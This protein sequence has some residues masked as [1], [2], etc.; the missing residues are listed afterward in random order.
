MI[1]CPYTALELRLATHD[2]SEEE[3]SDEKAQQ[4]VKEFESAMPH[5]KDNATCNQKIAE[6]HGISVLDLINSPNMDKLKADF[7]QKDVQLILDIYKKHG[8]NDKLAWFMV[9]NMLAPE[10][11]E[12]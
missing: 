6:F 4:I 2:V 1:K 8:L 3:L 7:F 11:L 12:F 9:M 5:Y 10:K